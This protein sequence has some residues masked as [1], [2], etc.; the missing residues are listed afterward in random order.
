MKKL[1]GVLLAIV[2][3]AGASLLIYPTIS[4]QWNRLHQ[5]HAV[6]SYTDR[7]DQ[8]EEAADEQVLEAAYAYN[9]QLAEN[10]PDGGTEGGQLAAYSGQLN[11]DAS[12]IM[13][14][15]NIPKIHVTLP[16]CHGT[17]ESVLQ[18][19][20]GHLET[21]SLPVG[22]KSFDDR[23]EKVT[24]ETDG[25]HCVI[26]G[27]RGLPSAKLFTDLD[28][29]TEGDR[30]SLTVLHETLTYEVDQIR[31]VE[32]TD[33]SNLQIVPGE[34]YCT[35]LT[36]TPYGIN[37]HR[38]LVRGH[39][40]ENDSDGVHMISDA[41]R[42]WP[43]LITPVAAAIGLLILLIA[44]V[45][46]ARRRK[47]NT[48][49]NKKWLSAMLTVVLGLALFLAAG[50]RLAQA[51]EAASAYPLTVNMAAEDYLKEDPELEDVTLNIYRLTESD[52]QKTGGNASEPEFGE[53]AV[54]YVTDHEMAVY[55]QTTFGSRTR[56]GEKGLYVVIPVLGDDVKRDAAGNVVV[57]TDAWVYTFSPMVIS[58]PANAVINVKTVRQ[59]TADADPV[60][61]KPEYR[62]TTNVDS[63]VT[64]ARDVKTGDIA[65]WYLLL[66]TAAAAVLAILIRQKKTDI[67]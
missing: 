18:T 41:F 51:A 66:I 54:S 42:F 5:T 16:I 34:D 2:L 62:Q 4:D 1:T 17:E 65:Q 15:V 59:P 37:T 27:H 36:C 32:P 60:W 64:K 21:T 53:A 19:A 11:L 6:M 13:G 45:V 48:D 44:L 8:M 31:V 56:L 38:L 46:V 7:V 67:R 3:I 55:A 20:V 24:D 29:L 10:G 9:H 28:R 39:R 35:L 43:D 50:D 23:Q 49:K 25:S 61:Q 33:R 14:Y 26:S 58:V 12:G 22:C 47:R 30:F 40:V 63:T 57:T 52:P